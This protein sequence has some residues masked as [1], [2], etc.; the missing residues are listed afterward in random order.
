MQHF[1]LS[2]YT[3]DPKNKII[4]KIIYKDNNVAAFALNISSGASLPNHTHMNSTVLIHV[5]KGSGRAVIDE[6][7]VQVNVGDILQVEGH[8]KFS[9]QNN[10]DDTLSMYV[11]LS[12]NPPSEHFTTDVEI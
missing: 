8:E 2:D 9:I 1:R 10:G 7:T 3:P 12:P 11:T 5:V 4:K 6:N